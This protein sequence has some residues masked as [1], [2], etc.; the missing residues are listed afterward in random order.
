MNR[1]RKHHHLLTP[2]KMNDLLA[3]SN[4]N[5][6]ELVESCDPA[7]MAINASNSPE[8]LQKLEKF[9]KDLINYL[10]LVKNRSKMQV[11]LETKPDEKSII[12]LDDS[13][14][15]VRKMAETETSNEK[16]NSRYPKVARNANEKKVSKRVQACISKGRKRKKSDSS[17]EGCD[18]HIKDQ[19]LQE[20][21][22]DDES[23]LSFDTEKK[24]QSEVSCTPLEIVSISRKQSSIRKCSRESNH[25]EEGIDTRF[26]VGHTRKILNENIAKL[27]FQA[28]F[29][30]SVVSCLRKKISH[31]TLSDKWNFLPKTTNEKLQY[32]LGEGER[33]LSLA[34]P[35]NP[36][37]DKQDKNGIPVF[38]NYSSTHKCHYIGHYRCVAFNRYLNECILKKG[39]NRQALLEFEFVRFNEVLNHKLSI[40]ES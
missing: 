21:L 1:S 36:R 34:S 5:P 9:A 39:K 37:T 35:F 24:S 19:W 6:L 31:I 27:G 10:E 4:N 25:C 13:D 17:S 33:R 11:R 14:S 18:D 20:D 23:L 30:Q 22:K 32:Y 3:L 40:L 12:T 29:G 8:M 2:L 7:A 28:K 26:S 16:K 38:W 15:E